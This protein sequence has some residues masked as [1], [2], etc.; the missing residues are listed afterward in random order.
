MADLILEGIVENGQT[1]LPDEV[2]LPE[3]IKAYEVIPAIQ[4]ARISH[5]Y[6]PRLAH[7][8]QAAGFFVKEV[9]ELPPDVEL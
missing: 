4:S 7:R 2:T 6:S 9:Y 8:E 1:R 3:H 5:I